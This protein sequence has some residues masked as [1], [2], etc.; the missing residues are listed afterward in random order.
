MSPKWTK[1]GDLH[2]VLTIKYT[3]MTTK[4][5]ALNAKNQKLVTK[6]A[7]LLIKYN[8]LSSLRDMADG[9][10]DERLY[11]RLDRKCENAFDRYLFSCDE[12]PQ[13]EVKNIDKLV[14]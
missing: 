1:Q 13:R 8:E 2:L 10:G 9:S 7:S 3:T 4:I 6:T 12:L 5:T 14:Y 11:S